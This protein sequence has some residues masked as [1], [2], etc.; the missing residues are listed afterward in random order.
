MNEPDKKEDSWVRKLVPIIITLA[1]LIFITAALIN[2][3]QYKNWKAEQSELSGKVK[4]TGTELDQ[5]KEASGTLQ[6]VKKN[7][8]TLKQSVTSMTVELE[9]KTKEKNSTNSALLRLRQ[10][11]SQEKQQL[12]NLNELVTAS[13][14][15]VAELTKDI[16][17]TNQKVNAAKSQREMLLKTVQR[18]EGEI[19]NKKSVL[20]SIEFLQ[21]QK[22]L[23]EQKIHDLKT[24]NDHTAKAVLGQ[25]AKFD[26]LQNKIKN[27]AATLQTQQEHHTTLNKELVEL[28]KSIKKLSSQKETIVMLGDQQKKLEYLEKLQQQKESMEIAISN[29]LQRGKMLE[30]KNLKLQQNRPTP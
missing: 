20:D 15:K 28:T 24:S 8:E 4:Q 7:A 1:V 26:A 13:K 6:D 22:S 17:K 11:L 27:G 3:K 19:V 18:L 29:L 10:E 23:L 21:R 2:H 12:K 9:K 14:N 16:E 30:A 25:Q 5:L